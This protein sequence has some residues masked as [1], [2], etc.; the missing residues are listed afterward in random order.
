MRSEGEQQGGVRGHR[1]AFSPVISH[2]T[3]AAAARE[4]PG[5]DGSSWNLSC[6]V[7]PER[8]NFRHDCTALSSEQSKT[9]FPKLRLL[10]KVPA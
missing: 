3:A 8:L 10:A 7:Q 9:P 5:E 1:A 2:C 4:P 6:L